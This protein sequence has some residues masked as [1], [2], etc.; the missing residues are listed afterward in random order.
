RLGEHVVVERDRLMIAALGVASAALVGDRVP[1]G[2]G[3]GLIGVVRL[4]I[5]RELCLVV[6]GGVALRAGRR[7]GRQQ[8][9]CSPTQNQSARKA[10]HAARFCEISPKRSTAQKKCAPTWRTQGREV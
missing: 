9:R 5:L 2:V 6:G 3:L 4:K 10:I 1:V 8:A 7:G